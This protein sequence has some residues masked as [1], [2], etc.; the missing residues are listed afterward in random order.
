MTVVVAGHGAD[1][2]PGDFV[3]WIATV[4]GHRS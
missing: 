4:S 3:K 1:D 2:D